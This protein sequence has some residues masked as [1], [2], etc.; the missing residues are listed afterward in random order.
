MFRSLLLCCLIVFSFGL[1][2]RAAEPFEIKNGDRVLFL[3]DT[4]LEREGTYGYLETRMQERFADRHFTVRN[5][6]YSADTP[7]GWSRA[8]F[9]PVA[10]GFERLKEQ[11]AIVK[12]TVVF[13]GYGM[14]ASLQEITDRSGDPTLNPDPVRYGAEPMSAP[15]FK[16][17]LGQLMDAINEISGGPVRYVL[18]SPI[19]HEDLRKLKP[20]LPDPTMH[21][22]L[23]EQYSAA[24]E[25]LAKERSARFVNIGEITKLANV[26][27]EALPSVHVTENGIHLN[28]LGYQLLAV[29]VSHELWPTDEQTQGNLTT[30]V[31]PLRAAI[32]RKNELF[33]HRWRPANSTYLF[34]FR[35]HEQGQNAKEIPEFDPLIEAADTRIDELKHA[36]KAPSKPAPL[37]PIPAVKDLAPVPPLPTPEFTLDNGLQIELW[38]ENPL[39]FKPTQMNWDPQGRLWVSSSA[40]YPMIT[41]GGEATDKILILGDPDHSGKATTSTIFADGLLL[42]TGVAPTPL[43]TKPGHPQRYGCFVGQSTEL[44]YFEDST[45]SGKA[46]QRHIVLS[47]FGTED[48]HHILHTLKF[49][50]DGRLYMDQSIY[51]H[52]HTETPWGVVRLNAGGVLA[53][54]PR[55][56]KV[57]VFDRGLWNS[58]GH[59]FDEWG[60]SFQTD[61]AGSTGLT[62]S[63]PGSIFAPSEGARRTLQSISPGSYPK[64]AS[65]ELI[66]SP[67]F[68]SDWQG[69]AITCD[70]RAHRIVRF[71]ITDLAKPEAAQNAST[72]P[73]QKHGLEAGYTTKELADVVRT[74]DVAFRPIDVKLG[75]DGALYVADWSNPVINHGEVDFRDP[76]RDHI[77]GRIWRITRKDGPVMQWEDLTKKSVD[78]IFS[79]FAQPGGP[80]NLWEREQ[81]VRVLAMKPASQIESAS[82]EFLGGQPSADRYAQLNVLRSGYYGLHL[83]AY[84]PPKVP[85]TAAQVRESIAG[86]SGD[87]VAQSIN[88]LLSQTAT[89]ETV[90]RDDPAKRD[91]FRAQVLAIVEAYLDHPHPRV[92]LGA[93]RV[94]GAIPTAESATLVLKAALKNGNTDPFLDFAA[95]KS[96]NELAKPWTE[97][98]VSGAWKTE[99]HEKELEYGLT[100]IDPELAGTALAKI[101]SNEKFDFT[102]GPWIDLIGKAGG[103]HELTKL[104]AALTLFY[105]PDC[106]PGLDTSTVKIP[107]L[108]EADAQRVIN[109]LSSAARDRGVRPEGELALE[110]FVE[111]APDVLRPGLLRLAGYWK[112]K[113]ALN[114]LPDIAINPPV[115]IPLRLAAID[116]L[117]ALG[118]NKAIETLTSLCAHDQPFAIRRAALAALAGLKLPVAVSQVQS[119]VKDA[120]SEGEAVQ[121]WRPLLGV[122]GGI[123]AI[124]AK[125]DDK[126]WAKELPPAALS[127][128]LKAARE[129]GYAGAFLVKSI[130][131]AGG[132]ASTTPRDMAGEIAGMV[133]A[134]QMGADPAQ[135]ELVYRRLVCVQC[136]SI[137]GAGG[138]LGPDLST[139]GASAPLDYIVESVFDP[140]AKIKEG[141]HAFAYTMK[142]GNVFTGIPTRETATEQFIRP[143]PAPEIPLIKANIVK[144]D[145]VGSLMPAGLADAL[146]YVEKRS[147]FAFLSQ[148]GR[149]GPFDASKT[150]IARLW[151]IYP[152]GQS[153]EAEHAEKID[154]QPTV[155]TLVDGRLPREQF[156]TALT[157][158][159]IP[160]ESVIATA[161]FQVATA[162]KT[163]FDLTGVSKAWLD[164]QPLAIA[165]EPNPDP[166]LA[167]GTHTLAVQLETKSLPDIFRVEVQG[168]SFLGN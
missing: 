126:D 52:T 127:A 139:I 69:T 101:L 64:F 79:L 71:S 42:P 114:L 117:R 128:A 44:L 90:F 26:L 107:N 1:A 43:P 8:S 10:K 67:H 58:W 105:G 157:P 86:L 130:E 111:A 135:G 136:H 45:G 160:G 13:L 50:P 109:A 102:K 125:F 81:A 152:G 168:A 66:H 20:G 23:L 73:N 41:P 70:F 120:P 151:R 33:F 164:G 106:C 27:P 150:S 156:A 159:N 48:T 17:E 19:R 78:A 11:I 122:Q 25:E 85:I 95:W 154:Q 56:E 82:R 4:L 12:P 61:G 16:R 116:G 22:Q 113:D 134:V 94:L 118:G 124:K 57:E 137:G 123:D 100:S 36:G 80:R 165:S 84:T 3:G 28:Q 76:R 68:A 141:F 110:K 34:G 9:D 93:V 18:L 147:L 63:F 112:T 121:T 148:L 108:S 74:S 132:K 31:S 65:L 6:A 91:A 75:P 38:A 72:D 104:F 47:G 144:K 131:A 60:Q 138:K 15:R 55:T 98:I 142:D 143:G 99:G 77:H 46:D 149:P 166:E 40:L 29:G 97:A 162:G 2:T 167:T 24:I 129:K 145:L 96:I 53:W 87:R 49:G 7:L 146:S 14:A 161:Q 103:P 140:N 89:A 39:L 21:N 37:A 119:V 59:Q 35:K 54:D 88:L 83:D 163:R 62:W 5:L 133:R 32:L 30:E 153:S 158:L 51:I 155:Y 92:R 115:K